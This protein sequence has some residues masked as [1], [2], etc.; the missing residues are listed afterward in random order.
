MD[1]SDLQGLEAE[2]ERVKAAI[3]GLREEQTHLQSLRNLKLPFFHLPPEICVTIFSF[4]C[5]KGRLPNDQNQEVVTTPFTISGVCRAWR[6]LAHSVPELWSSALLC[7]GSM[8]TS[9]RSR[10][11][12]ELLRQWLHLAKTLPLSISITFD[13][14]FAFETLLGIDSQTAI[15]VA[16]SHSH[17]WESVDLTLPSGLLLSIGCRPFPNLQSLSLQLT[18]EISSTPP[19]PIFLDAPTLRI[20]NLNCANKNVE[21]PYPYHQLEELTLRGYDIAPCL[22]LLGKCS[23]LTFC[24]IVKVSTN[25][26]RPAGDTSH[27]LETMH[28]EGRM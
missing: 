18:R 20:A 25:W 6:A 13:E 16:T 5:H 28:E 9:R 19:L 4:A 17:Q 3:Q 26:G 2:I 10:I 1:L 11:Q 12:A 14:R 21:L 15:M 27:Y 8:I 24:R 23:N 7:V 22:S